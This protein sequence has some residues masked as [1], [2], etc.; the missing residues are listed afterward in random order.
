MADVSETNELEEEKMEVNSESEGSSSSSDDADDGKIHDE[1][2]N[3]EAEVFGHY[4]FG[5]R[6]IMQR[7]YIAIFIFYVFLYRKPVLVLLLT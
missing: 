2:V 7:C 5:K 3:L 1:I 4:S 6:R